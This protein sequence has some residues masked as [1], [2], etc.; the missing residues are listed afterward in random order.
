MKIIG[1]FVLFIVSLQ[2]QAQIFKKRDIDNEIAN[3]QNQ[4][5]GHVYFTESIW[6]KN[7]NLDGFN[8]VLSSNRQDYPLLNNQ[9]L[10]IEFS[11]VSWR[12]DKKMKY[13]ITTGFGFLSTSP[14]LSSVGK[15]TADGGIVQFGFYGRYAL[16]NKK[17]TWLD[18]YAGSNFGVQTI[19]F[20]EQFS[21]KNITTPSLTGILNGTNV[22]KKQEGLSQLY[23]NGAVGLALTQLIRFKPVE[24]KL[25]S[26]EH[27]IPITVKFGYDTKLLAGKWSNQ[28][29]LNPQ[30]KSNLSGLNFSVGLGFYSKL[31]KK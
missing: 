27:G 11:G 4:I 29:E 22:S 24:G 21:G 8:E 28:Y 17:N 7:A 9:F 2:T 31:N 16:I 1:I 23:L 19:S 14:A 25:Y 12:T 6:I 15:W 30:P 26:Q 10:G 5:F 18:I 20:S 13:E 3:N